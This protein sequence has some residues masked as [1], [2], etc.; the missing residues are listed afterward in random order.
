M[1]P[2]CVHVSFLVS[3]SFALNLL[4]GES[5]YTGNEVEIEN[6][7]HKTDHGKQLHYSYIIVSL[8]CISIAIFHI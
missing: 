5:L 8:S 4:L 2:S 6:N 7:N 3:C 1:F